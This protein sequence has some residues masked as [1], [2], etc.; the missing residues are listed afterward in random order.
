MSRRTELWVKT[1][2]LHIASTCEHHLLVPIAAVVFRYNTAL[3]CSTKAVSV[4]QLSIYVYNFGKERPNLSSILE[5]SPHTRH[6]V[7]LV[8][9]TI[10]YD[11][12]KGGR[13]QT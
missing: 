4:T 13:L 8:F 7:V 1:C 10:T 11:V 3:Y 12:V 9:M 5:T 2:A 6:Q